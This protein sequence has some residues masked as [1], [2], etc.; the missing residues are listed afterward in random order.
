MAQNSWPSP[1]HNARAVTDVEYEKIA[2]RFSDDGVHGSPLDTQ[3]V[4]AGSG[5]A[6]NIRSGVYASVRGHAWSSGTS[7]VN[8]SI[9]ANSSG[10]TRV[11]LIL[12]RLDRSNWTVRAVVKQGT[13]GAG[14]PGIVQEDID[15]G[16]WEIYLAVVTVLNGAA[17]VSVKRNEL[18]VGTRVRPLTSVTPNPLALPGELQFETDTAHLSMYD[19]ATRKTV[20]SESGDVSCDATVASWDITVGSVLEARSGNVHLRLGTWNRSGGALAGASDSRLPVLIPSAFRH[21]T[22]N[23]YA[24]AYIT[25]AN[26]GRITIYPANNALAGQAWLTQKP[27][28]ATGADVLPGNVSWV[29]S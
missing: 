22:R 3:V 19:G 2:A 11:D 10:Q 8:L 7:T 6:V 5:L 1:S 4:S 25:G 12:L 9:A 20:Y 21:P 26:V 15:T 16:V 28:L 24:I 27:D 17:S 23:Q 13:P 14:A 18:Y 29:A